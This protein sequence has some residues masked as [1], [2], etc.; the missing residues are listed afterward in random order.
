MLNN[1]KLSRNSNQ[2][3]ADYIGPFERKEIV[4]RNSRDEKKVYSQKIFNSR[5]LQRKV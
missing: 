1:K 3:V 2:K 5:K 4:V